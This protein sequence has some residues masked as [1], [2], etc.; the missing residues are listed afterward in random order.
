MAHA[1][2]ASVDYLYSLESFKANT[3]AI[4]TNAPVMAETTSYFIAAT[5]SAVTAELE[6]LADL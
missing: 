3:T 6:N 4:Q 5:R 2:T 1:G